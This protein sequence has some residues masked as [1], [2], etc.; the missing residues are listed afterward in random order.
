[1][2]RCFFSILAGLLLA[3]PAHAAQSDAALKTALQHDLN[4]YLS[5][6]AKPEHISAISLSVSLHGAVQNINVTAGRTQ[7][8]GAGVPAT[9]DA[10]LADRQQ[11]KGVHGGDNLTARG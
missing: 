6:R 3:A 4:Q 9:P 1:M 2:K 5:A 7:Y 11:H 8:D 10:A